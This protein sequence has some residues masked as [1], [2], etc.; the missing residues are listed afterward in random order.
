MKFCSSSCSVKRAARACSWLCARDEKESSCSSGAET[1]KSMVNVCACVELR[2]DSWAGPASAEL[3]SMSLSMQYFN[4]MRVR[5][6]CCAWDGASAVRS[7][8]HILASTRGILRLSVQLACF[9]WMGLELTFYTRLAAHW[10][11]IV[12]WWRDRQHRH[13]V[14]AAATDCHEVHPPGPFCGK[15]CEMEFEE[16]HLLCE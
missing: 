15:I 13:A 4:G 2:P 7:S 9:E 11:D 5:T 6:S 12:F 10:V 16:M 3:S 14:R 1:A 8:Q